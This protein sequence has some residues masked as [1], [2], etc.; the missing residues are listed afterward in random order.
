[1]SLRGPEHSAKF[2]AECG[3]SSRGVRSSPATKNDATAKIYVRGGFAG[4]LSR[5]FFYAVKKK[6]NRQRYLRLS[7]ARTTMMDSA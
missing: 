1:V 4:L 7:F 2:A 5:F 6:T 3:V